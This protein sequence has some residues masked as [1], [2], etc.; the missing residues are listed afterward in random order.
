MQCLDLLPAQGDIK[1]ASCLASINLHPA[2]FTCEQCL[3]PQPSAFRMCLTGASSLLDCQLSRPGVPGTMIRLPCVRAPALQSPAKTMRFR[4]IHPGHEAS[5]NSLLHKSSRA[6]AW[7]SCS[8]AVYIM[9]VES[10]SMCDMLPAVTYVLQPSALEA[11]YV[12]ILVL[13]LHGKVN[14][15]N[16]CICVPGHLV[17]DGPTC[18]F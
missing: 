2:R 8:E 9:R 5:D 17:S 18:R 1:I 4:R 3:T 7:W 12:R 10:A 11:Q 14:S 16:P 13:L 15:D 6:S